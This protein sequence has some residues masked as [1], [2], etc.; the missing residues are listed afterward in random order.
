M[1]THEGLKLDFNGLYKDIHT[2]N[3]RYLHFWGGRARGGSHT[4]TQYALDLITREEYF[5]GYIMR[6]IAEDIRESLWRDF[7]DRIES[8]GC[9]DDIYLNDS[10]MKAFC[11]DTGNHLLSKGF[12]KSS[13][14]RT[15][16]LKS[17]AGATHVIIEEAEEISEEDFNQLDDTLRTIKANVQIILI[18]NPPSKNHWIWKKWY[19]LVDSD[20]P[21]YFTATPKKN[22]QLLS[23]FSTYKDNEIN[24]NETTIANFEAY[25]DSNPEHYYTMVKGLISEGMKGRIY[26]DWK[27]IVSMPNEY[28]KFYGLDWG[29]NDPVALVECE[30]HNN[31]LYVNEVIYGS[32]I[33]N[34]VL[35]RMMVDYGMRKS[36]PIFADKAPK[37]VADLE[38]MGWNIVSA[39]KGPGS[40]MAGIRFIKKYNV[41]LT[42]NSANLWKENENYRW[43]LDQ[44]KQPLDEPEDKNNH[45]MDALNYAMDYIKQP[46][47]Q[48]GVN[49]APSPPKPKPKYTFT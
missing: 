2:K 14:K 37:D 7:K 32:G 36:D 41:H 39:A 15:A 8:A 44:F 40:V 25:K 30:V 48:T 19:N 5:R 31:D 1:I 45:G 3:Y 38:K 27:P 4:A 6:E 12:K 16:K 34:D 20:I 35:S 33:T 23:I 24:L 46:T 11:P 28:T 21:G 29:F 49:I 47:G 17:L 43:R 13:G 9:E 18:F 26:K 22:Q 10:G 42:E